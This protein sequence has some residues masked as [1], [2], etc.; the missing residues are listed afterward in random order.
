VARKK[1]QAELLKQ[2]REVRAAP[3]RPKTVL[4]KRFWQDVT[5]Q[6]TAGMTPSQHSPAASS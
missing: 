6:E 2:A 5:V 4:Q 1:K 3:T